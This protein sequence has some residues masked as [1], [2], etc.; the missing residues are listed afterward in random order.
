M[1]DELGKEVDDSPLTYQS[2]D[3]FINRSMSAKESGIEPVK[4]VPNMNA[5][6]SGIESVKSVPNVGSLIHLSEEEEDGPIIIRPTDR[7]TDMEEVS[8][9][10]VWCPP[11]R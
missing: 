9:C 6:E 4:S 7:S 11:G 3:S 1:N 8:E 5:E 2:S 10:S